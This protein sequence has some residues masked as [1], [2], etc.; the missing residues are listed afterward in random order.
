MATASTK[1]STKR[2]HGRLRAICESELD[3]EMFSQVFLDVDRINETN[4][5]DIIENTGST[6]YI[7]LTEKLNSLLLNQ[8]YSDTGTSLPNIKRP[9]PERYSYAARFGHIS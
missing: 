5:D 6:H 4:M 8:A 7:L 3:F 1:H 9:Q 2:L